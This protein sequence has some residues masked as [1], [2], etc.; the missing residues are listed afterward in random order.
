MSSLAECRHERHKER[1]R[2]P[3]RNI[4]EYSEVS[5]LCRISLVEHNYN[6]KRDYSAANSIEKEE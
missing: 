6:N 1:C 5:H 3:K 4:D 2:P